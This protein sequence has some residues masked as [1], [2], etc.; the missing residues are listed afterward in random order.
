ME[1]GSIPDAFHPSRLFGRPQKVLDVTDF[2]VKPANSR[3]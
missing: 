1:K 3:L 2:E